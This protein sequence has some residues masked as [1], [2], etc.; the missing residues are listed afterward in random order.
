[1]SIIE[2]D[3]CDDVDTLV[4]PSAPYSATVGMP[5]SLFRDIVTTLEGTTCEIGITRDGVLF[6]SDNSSLSILK[7]NDVQVS[8]KVQKAVKLV[9]DL[10]RLRM[11]AKMDS[12]ASSTV[13]LSLLPSCPLR[14]QFSTATSKFTTYLSLFLAPIVDDVEGED[15]ETPM[16]AEEELELSH[17]IHSS[18]KAAMISSET[19]SSNARRQSKRRSNSINR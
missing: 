2:I 1:M 4:L 5:S 16:T 13:H 19:T 9:F 3:C 8:F 15:C 18:K 11:F 7:T 12:I 10:S 17:Q 6:S 14:L